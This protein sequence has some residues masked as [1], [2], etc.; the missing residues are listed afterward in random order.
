MDLC[1]SNHKELCYNSGFCPA[2]EIRDELQEE[3]DTLNASLDELTEELKK[4]LE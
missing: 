1:S 2:C 3:I 4:E